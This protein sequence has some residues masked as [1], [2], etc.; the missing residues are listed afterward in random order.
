MNYYTS[1]SSF[2]LKYDTLIR[3]L[4]WLP[5]RLL[6]VVMLVL[7]V[8]ILSGVILRS[9]FDLPLAWVEELARYMMVWM[10]FLGLPIIFDRQELIAVLLL[11]TK[12][13]KPIV[14]VIKRIIHLLVIFTSAMLLY[15][16]SIYTMNNADSTM[17]SMDYMSMVWVYGALPISFALVIIIEIKHFLGSFLS[18]KENLAIK[19]I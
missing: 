4:L 12:L 16:S 7:A 9:C 11:H 15:Y 1:D 2:M 14:M 19:G 8:S 6:I 13:P 3:V 18:Q 10:T 5:K 17:I